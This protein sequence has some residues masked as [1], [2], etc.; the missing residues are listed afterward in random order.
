MFLNRRNAG[1]QLFK[2]ELLGNHHGAE[3]L[4]ISTRFRVSKRVGEQSRVSAGLY[5]AG[6]TSFKHQVSFLL[7][8]SNKI[9]CVYECHIH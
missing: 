6:S 7:H 4:Q 2:R 8:I 5:G 1:L 9:S 3:L